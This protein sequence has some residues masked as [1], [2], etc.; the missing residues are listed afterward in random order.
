MRPV[1]GDKSAQLKRMLQ[2]GECL[3]WEGGPTPGMHLQPS[4][5]F[6]IPFSLL[7]C[8]FAVFWESSVVRTGA[9]VLL[10]LWGVPLILMGLY[11]V[12]GRFFH[13][14]WKQKRTYYGVTS[15]RV[16]L[17]EHS[18]TKFVTYQQIPVL[19]KHVKSNGE[20]TVYLSEP[21]AYY[22]RGSY[23]R[24][25]RNRTALVNIPDAERVYRLIEA[26]MLQGS[27]T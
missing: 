8:G 10:T 18:G 21:Q 19:E 5:G 23:R 20:G 4:D 16:I 17:M 11:M 3:L 24:D 2:P 12:I 1:D 9:P 27:Q 13:A 22:R 7:W 25:Y 26:N 6:V 15:K 14:T